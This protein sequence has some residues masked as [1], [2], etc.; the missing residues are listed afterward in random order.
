MGATSTR[1]WLEDSLW[2]QVARMAVS[3][4][5]TV[6]ELLPRLIA[7]SLAGSLAP[8]LPSAPRAT[9]GPAADEPSVTAGPPVVTLAEAYR[10]GE[11]GAQIKTAG[12]SAHLGKHLR[13]RQAAETE[14]S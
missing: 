4:G 14:R 13:E 6:R 10:C 8:P 12:L 9:V 7:G 2:D 1:I 11:C 5:T 3:E